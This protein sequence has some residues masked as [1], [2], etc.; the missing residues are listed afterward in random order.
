MGDLERR[1]ASLDVAEDCL[2]A[3]G[4]VSH[5]IESALH[6]RRARGALDAIEKRVLVA[7]RNLGRAH[8]NDIARVVALPPARAR[9]T[10]AW[11]GQSRAVTH[12]LESLHHRGALRVSHRERG[13]RVYTVAPTR[14]I[15][16]NATRL[17]T[18][19]LA[20]ANALAPVRERTLLANVTR[21]RHLGDLRTT[22]DK[23]VHEGT[24]QREL[25]SGETYLDFPRRRT[26]EPPRIVRFL[27]PFDPLLW[28]RKRLEHLFGFTYR[29]EAYT[30]ARA[31]VRGY[32]ALP[33]LFSDS[34]IGHANV[35]KGAITLGF[36][37]R[38]RERTFEVELEKEIVRIRTFAK[39]VESP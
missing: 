23:L 20:V 37:R 33:I 25:E 6:P 8:P 22:I 4:F 5:A 21:F 13:V 36:E 29:F 19:V 12:A 14:A 38:P 10:N 16:P 11:G 27:A 31:R 35:V 26:S 18:L 3:Y 2:Y 30:P 17:R 7:V 24:L 28:D 15:A 1:Y 34:V 39:L 9:V 32:Y